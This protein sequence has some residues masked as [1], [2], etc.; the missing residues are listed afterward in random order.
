MKLLEENTGQPSLMRWVAMA[1]VITY[2]V[3]VGVILTTWVI[4]SFLGE[5]DWGF[6]LKFTIAVGTTGLGTVVTK[7]VQKKYELKN[8]L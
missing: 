2:M 3:V 1:V 6:A 4:K 8:E 7:V 5:P